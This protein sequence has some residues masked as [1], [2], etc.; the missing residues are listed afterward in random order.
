[1]KQKFYSIQ[2]ALIFFSFIGFQCLTAQTVGDIIDAV[3]TNS[4]DLYLNEFSGE[5]STVV[6][7]NS[8]TLIN[9]VSS[10]GNDLA[11][12]YL[13][14]KF[15]SFGNLEIN[16]NQYSNGGRN[17][18][19]TQIGKTNPDN[20]YIVCGHYDSVADY[21]ADD[22]ATGTAAVLETARIL[23]QYCTDNTIVYALWDEEEIGLVGSADYAEKAKNNGDNI[24]GVI[25]MDMIGYDKNQN[26]DVHIHARDVANSVDLQNTAIA[27]LNDH[28]SKIGLTSNPVNPGIGSSDHQSF[29][30]NG[31]SAII[32]SEAETRNDLTPNYHTSDDR[33]ST[34]DLPYFHKISKLATGTTASLAGLISSDS[35]SLSVEESNILEGVN[36]FPNPFVNTINVALS[37]VNNSSLKITNIIGQVINTQKLTNKITQINLHNL[38][39]GMY[40]ITITSNNKSLTKKIVKK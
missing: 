40:F 24:L 22:N 34:L 7:N 27:V 38:P 35:C 17:I 1:M 25:N 13:I 20:I 31:F 2:Y 29:W 39:R 37:K 11:A 36:I 19:A 32:L 9:R 5:V 14:E 28:S 33:V 23:S 30:D 26:D 3:D 8:V 4:L 18:I 15:K 6:N 21:C 10:Q 16:D 12:E